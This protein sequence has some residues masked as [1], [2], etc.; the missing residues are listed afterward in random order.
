MSGEILTRGD[1]SKETPWM[2]GYGDWACDCSTHNPFTTGTIEAQQWEEGNT[3]A[4]KDDEH[5]VGSVSA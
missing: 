1:V 3:E 4:R 2:R 5:N